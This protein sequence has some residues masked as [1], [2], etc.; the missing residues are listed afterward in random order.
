MAISRGVD[1]TAS[2]VTA[3]AVRVAVLCGL[4]QMLDGYD[5]SAVGLAAPAII[6]A[7]GVKPV[8]LTAAFAFSS[9]GIMV[10]AMSAGEHASVK[11]P[12][13]MWSPRKTS[14]TRWSYG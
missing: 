10:G 1:G 8:E 13:A 3:S 4:V 12:F 7:W 9:I 5:L 6:K 14:G 2:R 11:C